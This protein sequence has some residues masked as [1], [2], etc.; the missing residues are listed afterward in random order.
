MKNMNKIDSVEDFFRATDET[1]QSILESSTLGRRALKQALNGNFTAKEILELEKERADKE[2]LYR[3]RSYFDEDA[4]LD[5]QFDHAYEEPLDSDV[6]SAVLLKRYSEIDQYQGVFTARGWLSAV[7][8]VAVEGG[9]I[10]PGA[11][12]NRYV[13]CLELKT[14]EIKHH[15]FSEKFDKNDPLVLYIP[16]F[17]DP[18]IKMA[19]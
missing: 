7:R 18:K 6:E 3:E 13:I 17:N 1:H 16:V 9:Q 2:K 19:L 10:E 14:T 15:E 12:N 4:L 5:I 8:V 11:N